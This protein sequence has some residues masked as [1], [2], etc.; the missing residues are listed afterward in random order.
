M[1]R[2]LSDVDH[3]GDHILQIGKLIDDE[4]V[5]V[6]V[7]K[8]LKPETIGYLEGI[9]G[10]AEERRGDVIREVFPEDVVESDVTG[11]RK[12]DS[13]SKGCEF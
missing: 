13:F 1:K 7:A 3:G 2:C 4:D 5:L 12:Q 9:A 10:E 6:L 8:L 11:D